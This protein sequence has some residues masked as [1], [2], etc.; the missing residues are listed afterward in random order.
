MQTNPAPHTAAV[1]PAGPPQPPVL[2]EDQWLVDRC[3]GAGGSSSVWLVEQRAGG[4]RYALKMPL[5]RTTPAEEFEVRRELAIA[6]RYQHENLLGVEGVLATAQGPGLLLEYAPG[7]S[8]EQLLAARGTLG[9]GEVVTVLVAVGRAL[10]C[11]HAEGTVHG[12]VAPGN[13]LFTAEGKPLLAGFG[14]A[15]PVQGFADREDGSPDSAPSEGA[16]PHAEGTGPAA[17]VYALGALGWFMLTGRTLLPGLRPPL[18]VLLPGLPSAL[19]DLVDSALGENPG[20]RPEAGNFAARVLRA[21]PAEPVGLLPEKRSADRAE[22]RTRR[23]G[24]AAKRG[25]RTLRRGTAR[26]RRRRGSL[27]AAQGAGRTSWLITATLLVGATAVLGAV[28]LAAPQLLRPETVRLA[29]AA[30]SPVAEPADP[31]P[32]A[33]AEPSAEEAAALAG[34]DPEAA[35][36][37]LSVLRARA[38][39]LGSVQLLRWV[40]KPGSPAEEADLEQVRALEERGERLAG[41]QVEVLRTSAVAAESESR[42]RIAV[43]ARLTEW[44][45]VR[46]DGSAA[47][48]PGGPVRQEV[49][50]ELERTGAQW[51]ISAV[52]PAAASLQERAD[53]K[54]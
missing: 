36:R 20:L 12:G 25:R 1:L 38:F 17:D 14:A 32:G 28:A 30:E 42:A 43:S 2:P 15:K 8:L 40:N 22:L 10:A 50:L 4:G 6:S 7:G 39:E 3:L 21:C 31:R 19:R 41:L 35:A 51:W 37:V 11:L 54:R 13:V 18:S 45:Q 29:P 27:K 47:A 49:L 16:A 53:A 26:R 44:Q 9:P 24:S 33:N 5:A 34:G 23:T 52:L 46:G 48:G